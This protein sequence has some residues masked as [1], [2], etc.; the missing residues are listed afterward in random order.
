MK[1][2]PEVWCKLEYQCWYF[3][4][5]ISLCLSPFSSTPK[6][7][8]DCSSKG[9]ILMKCTY[10]G[11]GSIH[12]KDFVHVTALVD[13]PSIL[14]KYISNKKHKKITSRNRCLS[15][16]TNYILTVVWQTWLSWS[17]SEEGQHVLSR[18]YH[19]KADMHLKLKSSVLDVEECIIM[20][21][22][23]AL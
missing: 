6:R 16:I 20:C 15:Y 3:I 4:A 10:L 5:S 12:G 1:L 18:L 14:Y 9:Q 7:K 17:V 22:T 13:Y 21:K 11:T 23:D 2:E 8:I 19:Q